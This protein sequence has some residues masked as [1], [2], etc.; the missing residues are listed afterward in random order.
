MNLG[1]LILMLC[2]FLT[3]IAT[4]CFF[5]FIHKP[6]SLRIQEKDIDYEDTSEDDYTD[7][8]KGPIKF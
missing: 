6:A 1:I 8:L 4:Y 7:T 2:V 3:I 5:T